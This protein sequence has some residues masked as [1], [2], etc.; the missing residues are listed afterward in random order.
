LE[1]VP[2][3]GHEVDE[4]V[5]AVHPKS[6]LADNTSVD[7]REIQAL[8]LILKE[9]GSGIRQV[10]MAAV[11]EQGVSLS[12]LLEAGSVPF[13]KD[14]VAKG[15]GVSILTRISVEDE[16]RAGDLCAISFAGEGLWV[17]VDIVVPREGYRSFA[18]R[19]FLQYLAEYAADAA[20]ISP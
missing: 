18:V 19:A 12:I 14:L 9:R 11:E 10:V 5:L 2:F 17:H 8:P 7:L 20:E 15:A 3:P 6:P 16:V 13:I 1:V 4:L